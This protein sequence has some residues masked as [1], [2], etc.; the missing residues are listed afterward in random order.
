MQSNEVC[1]PGS[2]E[3][4][5]AKYDWLSARDKA[6]DMATRL[7]EQ[8]ISN[9][10]YNRLVEPFV[11]CRDVMTFTR[12]QIESMFLLRHPWHWHYE[13]GRKE[14]NYRVWED[15]VNLTFPTEYNFQDLSIKL[16]K[17]IMSSSP[18][19]LEAGEWHLP[20]IT[21]EDRLN[22]PQSYADVWNNTSLINLSSARCAM[23]S[24]STNKGRSLEQELDLA[25]RLIKENHWSPFEHQAQALSEDYR[26][27]TT[28]APKLNME[29]PKGLEARITN[30]VSNPG[31][32]DVDFYSRNLKGYIQARALLDGDS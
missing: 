26:D 10:I 28:D 16:R 18:K 29:L 11:V 30:S 17:A 2:K 27:Y 15:K 1:E 19:V 12:P 21:D 32:F 4:A 25:N 6:A 20:F 23:T 3:E 5:D 24:Y 8:G 13:D 7:E 9:Q 22:A 14:G 31:M